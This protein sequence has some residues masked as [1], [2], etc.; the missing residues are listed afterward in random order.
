MISEESAD[1]IGQAIVTGT[2]GYS[3]IE[4]VAIVTSARKVGASDVMKTRADAAHVITS[5]TNG[6]VPFSRFRARRRRG[7]ARLITTIPPERLYRSPD[8]SGRER[9]RG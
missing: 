9:V 8:V 5:H 2:A 7:T 1:K 3:P 4:F 6:E